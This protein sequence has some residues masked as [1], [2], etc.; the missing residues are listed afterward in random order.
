MSTA[1][2]AP[3]RSFRDVVAQGSCSRIEP[4]YKVGELV[5]ATVR[6]ESPMSAF[7]LSCRGKLK[8][9]ER[10]LADQEAKTRRGNEE[11]GE[12]KGSRARPCVILS[13]QQL[14]R[15]TWVYVLCLLTSFDNK[16]HSQLPADEKRLALPVYQG[17]GQR[18]DC[19][20]ET[21]IPAF[22][23]QPLLKPRAYS[24][25]IGYPITRS[26]SCIQRVIGDDKPVMDLGE[27]RRLK[28]HCDW[29]RDRKRGVFSK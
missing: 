6:V 5:Y 4:P 23:F 26:G 3:R 18:N 25:I 21:G 28:E 24:Y 1:A 7:R 29:I 15:N 17:G 27:V 16:A 22:V 14:T 11:S 20:V 13:T 19:E 12:I 2:A 9:K 8:K 10:R